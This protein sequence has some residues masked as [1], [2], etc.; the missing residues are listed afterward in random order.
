M[1]RTSSDQIHVTVLAMS[2]SQPISQAPSYISDV[3]E[4]NAVTLYHT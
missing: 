4:L 2:F 3:E 1:S